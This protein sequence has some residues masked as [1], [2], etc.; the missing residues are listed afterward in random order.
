MVDGSGRLVWWEVSR[1][2]DS[3]EVKE[4]WPPRL[5]LFSFADYVGFLGVDSGR[6]MV[7]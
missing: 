4:E 3:V 5:A 2:D 7:A 1:H 6:P